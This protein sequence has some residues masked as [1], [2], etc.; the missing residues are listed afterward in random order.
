MIHDF[1][2]FEIIRPL[3]MVRFFFFKSPIKLQDH[4]SSIR[5]PGQ[6]CDKVVIYGSTESKQSRS[7]KASLRVRQWKITRKFCVFSTSSKINNLRKNIAH[8]WLAYP[9]KKALC[10]RI[11]PAGI[12][13][14]SIQKSKKQVSWTGIIASWPSAI[15]PEKEKWR[16]PPRDFT[17]HLDRRR[18]Q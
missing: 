8:T 3:L 6:H 15:I 13:S 17:F 7:H 18:C 11:E 5:R 16:S 10:N 12:N 4:P 2:A 14:G 9:A 1:T